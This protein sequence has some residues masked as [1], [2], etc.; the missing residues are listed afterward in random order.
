MCRLSR[1]VELTTCSAKDSVAVSLKAMPALFI[2]MSHLHRA[3]THH[4][5]ECAHTPP[6][7][8][9]PSP[10]T[11]THHKHTHKHTT[12][13]HHT[14]THSPLAS[15]HAYTHAIGLHTH[16]PT[17]FRAAQRRPGLAQPHRAGSRHRSTPPSIPQGSQGPNAVTKFSIQLTSS[18]TTCNLK[19][20]KS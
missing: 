12:H 11:H 14:H 17:T 13:T 3:H 4:T 15:T 7:P 6:P 19:T 18:S 9:P 8:P 20:S 2:R 16:T 5:H 1:G 10:H